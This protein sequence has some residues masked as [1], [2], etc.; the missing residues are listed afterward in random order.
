DAWNNVTFTAGEVKNPRRNLPLSLVFGTGMVIVLYLLANFAYLA[1][2]PLRGDPQLANELKVEAKAA[3]SPAEKAAVTAKYDEA[4]F[5]LGIDQARGDRVGT[6]VLQR[7]SPK[8]GV[9]FMALAIMISTFGCVN[10]M[11]L[12][13]ARLYYAMAQDRLFFQSVGRLNQRGVPA[14]GL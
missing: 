14:A 3:A 2:L 5:A 9:P 4:A 6:A 8:L 12:M 13:G 11:T 7:A 1:A 10:G